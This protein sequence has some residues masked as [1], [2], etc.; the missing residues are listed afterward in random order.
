MAR[1]VAAPSLAPI[2]IDRLGTPVL[3][4]VVYLGGLAMTL[5]SAFKALVHP[6]KGAPALRTALVRQL[7]WLLGAGLP[8]VG[9]VHVGLGSFLAMQ[10]Y[11]GAVFAEAVG[12]LVMVGLF[13]NVAPLL[14]GMILAGLLAARVTADLARRP[15]VELDADPGWVPDRPV[16]LGHQVNPDL[17]PEPARL[18]GV[19]IAS[20]MIAGPVLTLWGA[21]VGTCIGWLISLQYLGVPT[22]IFFTKAIE[23]LWARDITGVFVKGTCFGMVAALFACYEGMRGS[24]SVPVSAVRAAALSAMS[25][26]LINSIYYVLMYMAGPAFGPTVLTPPVP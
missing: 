19:R 1:D 23:M 12:P 18:A 4:G 8:L 7:E 22:P 25:I 17:P 21:T 5:G 11:Y 26:L 16:A 14:S 6:P 15:L 10:A 9:L 20:A 24:D 2:T 3:Q 13:R